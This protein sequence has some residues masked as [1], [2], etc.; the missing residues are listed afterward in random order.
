MMRLSLPECKLVCDIRV[1]VFISN[2]LD[3]FDIPLYGLMRE[4]I[5]N[6]TSGGGCTKDPD[7]N[8]VLLKDQDSDTSMVSSLINSKESNVP[9]GLIIGK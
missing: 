4:S 3:D 9:V 7:G 6:H 8:L 5:S 2:L 1:V